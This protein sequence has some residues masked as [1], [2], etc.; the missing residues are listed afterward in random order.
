M[1][2][3]RRPKYKTRINRAGTPGLI[4]G[5]G[6]NLERYLYFLHRVTGVGILLYLILHIFA[7]SSRMYGKPAYEAF[8]Q[9]ISNPLADLGLFIVMAALVFHGVNG[10]RLILNEYGFLLGKP[11]RPVYPYRE[12][13]KTGKPRL[14]IALMMVTGIIILIII[15]I[16]LLMVWGVLG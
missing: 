13:L 7:T 14:L 5:R 4:G 12:V 1:I 6:V 15:A 10:I 11:Q 9:A 8:H 3:Y 16:E 2:K